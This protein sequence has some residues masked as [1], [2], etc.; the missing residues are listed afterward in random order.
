MK[1]QCPLSPGLWFLKGKEREL[2]KVKEKE[3]E[4][5][6]G[7]ERKG[8]ERKN[9]PT[10]FRDETPVPTGPATVSTFTAGH[11]EL[12]LSL[13][14]ASSPL[15]LLGPSSGFPKAEEEEGRDRRKGGRGEVTLDLCQSNLVFISHDLTRC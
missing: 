8:E 5:R 11:L 6:R 10:S 15:P 4:G 7:E 1:V 14:V 13:P 9:L 2:R 12:H 3:G